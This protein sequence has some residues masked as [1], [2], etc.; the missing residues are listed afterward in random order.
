MLSASELKGIVPPLITPVD[1][2]ENVDEGGLIR[3]IDHVLNGG[4]HGV[5]VLGAMVNSMRLM[6]KT[7]EVPLT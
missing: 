6:R 1:S 3:I 4:V 7:R 5:F 2:K